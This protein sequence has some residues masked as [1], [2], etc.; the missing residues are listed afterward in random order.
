M[1]RVRNA[2][3][4]HRQAG[5]RDG[6]GGSWIW[7]RFRFRA[8]DRALGRA[9][10][11]RHQCIGAI[12]YSTSRPRTACEDALAVSNVKRIPFGADVCKCRQP[13]TVP[14]GAGCETGDVYGCAWLLAIWYLD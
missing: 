14:V 4:R 7:D 2:G 5:S 12:I 6:C 1:A 10:T 13:T 9:G 8:Q 3:V 11:T